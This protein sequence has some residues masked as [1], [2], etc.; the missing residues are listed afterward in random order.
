MRALEEGNAAA[1]ER[2]DLTAA[3]EATG[4]PA[5]SIWRRIRRDVLLLGAGS[6]GTVLAQLVFRSVLVVVLA[7]AAYG[8]LSLVLSV[9]NAAWIVGAGGL[10]SGVAR[11]IA[12]IAPRDDS[13]VVRSAFRAGAWPATLA[14]LVVAGVAAAVLGSP[15]AF[16]YG[17]VGLGCFVYAMIAM[18]ILRGRGRIGAASAVMPIGGAG[19]VLALA[20]LVGLGATVT[21]VSAFGI[22]C[23][24]NVLGGL[25]GMMFVA[26]RRSSHGWGGEAPASLAQLGAPSARELLGFS[27]WLGLATAG[28]AALPVVV[29]FA[30]AL[31][32]Y[33]VVAVVDVA[34]VLLSIPL[35]IGSVIVG[36]VVPHATRALGSPEG[37]VTISTRE[38]AIVIAP[39]ALGALLVAS[40]NVV[41]WAFGLLG[42][43][44]YGKA[45]AYLALALLAGPA[46]VLY[47]LVEGVLVARGEARFLAVNSLSTALAASGA[48]IVTA[49]LGSMLGAFALFVASCWAVYVFGLV[50]VRRGSVCDEALLPVSQVAVEGG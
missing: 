24:G 28:I 46:R 40:T 16:A 30:A 17:A 10:P 50:R 26:R 18:G 27:I 44:E 23:L 35:R 45:S 29:R 8:R 5:A 32:S 37:L 49:A 36:A 19:E 47:G 42:R 39:F 22:F 12:A 33:T 4:S 34:L 48:V 1:M 38:Q 11:H 2:S 25:A 43:A 3:G 20:G 15:L 41:G 21:P 6:M 7:P 31:D 13:A 9:Y 14:A